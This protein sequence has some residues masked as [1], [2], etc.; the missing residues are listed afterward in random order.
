MNL[1]LAV[2]NES[3]TKIQKNPSQSQ[4]RLAFI[5]SLEI[6]NQNSF[7]KSITIERKM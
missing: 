5:P 3:F 7:L 6:S 2:I 4:S 1:I